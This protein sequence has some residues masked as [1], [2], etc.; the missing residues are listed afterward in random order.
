MQSDDLKRVKDDSM[1]SVK[2]MQG[3]GIRRVKSDDVKSLEASPRRPWDL[4]PDSP[5]TLDTIRA[6]WKRRPESILERGAMIFVCIAGFYVLIRLLHQFSSSLKPLVLATIFVWIL[7]PIVQTFEWL[8]RMAWRVVMFFLTGILYRVL[9]AINSLLIRC[10]GL[11]KMRCKIE[12]PDEG[13]SCARRCQKLNQRFRKRIFYKWKGTDAGK[14]VSLRLLSITYTLILVSLIVYFG[15]LAI[16]QSVQEMDVGRYAQEIVK[17]QVELNHWLNTTDSLPLDVK[18]K[19]NHW[20]SDWF[21]DPQSRLLPA[22]EAQ[23]TNFLEGFTQSSIDF[24]ISL[25]FFLLYTFLWLSDPLHLDIRQDQG[26]RVIQN[27]KPR[28]ASRVIRAIEKRKTLLTPLMRTRMPEEIIFEQDD[29]DEDGEEDAN[30]RG[31]TSS[32]SQVSVENAEDGD[33]SSSDK[34]ADDEPRDRAPSDLIEE[35]QLRAEAAGRNSLCD[36]DVD[37]EVVQK[38]LQEYVYNIIKTYFMLKTLMNAVFGVCVYALLSS[39]GVS[40]AALLAGACFF[41][42]YIPEIGAFISILMPIPLI[43]LDPAIPDLHERGMTTLYVVLGM[44]LIKLLVSNL[45]ETKVM[46]K[47]PSLAGVLDSKKDGGVEETHPV[48]ILFAVVV[49]GQ[50]WGQLGMLISVPVISLARLTFSVWDEIHKPHDAAMEEK[51]SA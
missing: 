23:F 27:C 4:S 11:C 32:F 48:F 38:Q 44:L 8:H 40:L 21:S 13:F 20:M 19:I 29:A 46:S 36:Q 1:R 43:L 34:E 6:L 33:S 2:V 10:F 16:M 9:D 51:K 49:S 18:K 24:V 37:E 50:V 15:S 42:S 28:E 35:E 45:I 3:D 47:N 17:Y 25:I 31:I 5:E 14:Y 41:L 12:C 26:N 22:A 39:Y 7:E 30:D